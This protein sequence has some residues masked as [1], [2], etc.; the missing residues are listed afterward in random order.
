MDQNWEA[1]L[2]LQ[3]YMEQDT[4]FHEDKMNNWVH[5]KAQ[6]FEH[7]LLHFGVVDLKSI[8]GLDLAM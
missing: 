8:S 5:I 1:F 7:A 3:T 6:S 2:A 4:N